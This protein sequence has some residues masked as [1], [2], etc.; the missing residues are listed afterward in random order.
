MDNTENKLTEK[1]VLHIGGV[2]CRSFQNII[3]MI[4][5]GMIIFPR[6]YLH[7]L[8]E[9]K[10][11]GLIDCDLYKDGYCAVRLNRT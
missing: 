9:M 5:R 4:N 8:G 6:G 7:T 2:M 1:E 3:E 11:Q 10:R